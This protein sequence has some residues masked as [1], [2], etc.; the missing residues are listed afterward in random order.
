MGSK[1]IR[2]QA[3]KRRRTEEALEK[4]E[5]RFRSAFE[6]APVGMAIVGLDFEIRQVNPALCH[7]LGYSREELLAC[8]FLEL[9]HPDDIEKDLELAQRLV[10]GKVENYQL[11][12]RY[13][14]KDGRIIWGRLSVTLVRDPDGTASYALAILKDFSEHKEIVKLLTGMP[15]DPVRQDAEFSDTSVKHDARPVEDLRA[16]PIE[17]TIQSQDRL[18]QDMVRSLSAPVVVL[19][20]EGTIVYASKSW[21]LL[22]PDDQTQLQ[23]VAL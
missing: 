16:K 7:L 21:D 6:N 3:G 2:S 19:D 23:C 14:T 8:T 4:S 22:T 5:E 12:K 20:R 10:N 18:L 9:T 1:A 17:T 13:I 15:A 11:E